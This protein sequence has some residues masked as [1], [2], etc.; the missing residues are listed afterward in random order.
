MDEKAELA[1]AKKVR[2][3]KTDAACRLEIA[4]QLYSN[5]TLQGIIQL[6]VLNVDISSF[7]EKIKLIR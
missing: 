7:T 3:A 5:T 6:Y 2:R 4:S 1:V